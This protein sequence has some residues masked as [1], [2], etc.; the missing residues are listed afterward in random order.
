MQVVLVAKTVNKSDDN[1]T[2]N[3]VDGATT[4]NTSQLQSKDATIETATINSRTSENNDKD[5]NTSQM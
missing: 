2:T 1:N 4:I 5:I 3:I